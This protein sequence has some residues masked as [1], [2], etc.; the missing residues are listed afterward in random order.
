MCLRVLSSL[1]VLGWADMD[2]IETLPVGC[3]GGL[4]TN[5][6]SLLQASQLQGTAI[7]LEN[8]EPTVEGGYRRINGYTKWNAKRVPF[9]GDLYTVGTYSIGATAIT[10]TNLFPDDYTEFTN[11]LTFTIEISSTTY[12]VTSTSSSNFNTR[13]ITVNFTPALDVNLPTTYR[14]FFD[15]YLDK[16][17]TIYVSY[18]DGVIVVGPYGKVFVSQNIY[19]GGGL[20]ISRDGWRW[21]PINNGI[22]QVN[23]AGQTGNSLNVKGL[24]FA[25]FMGDNFVLNNVFYTVQFSTALSNGTSTLTISPNLSSS[26]SDSASITWLSSYGSASFI[27]NEVGTKDS[28]R[29]SFTKYKNNILAPTISFLRT[30]VTG[31]RPFVIDR[32][33]RLYIIADV[34]G[35]RY[36]AYF[37][38]TLF[39]AQRSNLIFSA[40]YNDLN[41]NVADG[42]G[43]ISFGDQ[44]TGLKSLRD[45]LIV[46]C[47][48]SIYRLIGSSSED[49]RTE[50]ISSSV[51]CISDN[52]IKEING[53]VI[54]MTDSGLCLL[55]DTEKTS[56]L[57]IT[58]VSDKIKAEIN[59]LLTPVVDPFSQS[60]YYNSIYI[61]NKS[62]YRVFQFKDSVTDANSI[63]IIASKVDRETSDLSFSKLKGFKVFSCDNLDDATDNSSLPVPHQAVFANGTDGWV[64]QM[65]S[66][67]TFDGTNITATYSTPYY[68][69]NDSKFRKTIHKVTVYTE[70]E[71][72]VT[73]TIDTVLD[74]N[75]SDIIQPPP[76]IVGT[77]GTTYND[78]TTPVFS[79]PLIGNGYSVSLK[80][81]S[82]TNTPPYVIQSFTVE[83]STND[84]R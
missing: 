64:Y 61:K 38:N 17:L 56:G 27:D 12:T 19:L 63:G 60:V 81:T 37:K 84:R 82:N 67:N 21:I 1:L 75:K 14:L 31:D 80:F 2:R 54:F 46:F 29:L 35:V 9:F 6:P 59:N 13:S 65:D 47:K 11:G 7:D 62:Q 20:P 50:L 32:D 26:P 57:G 53:D 70:A 55:S 8:F 4:V 42:A 39:F 58:L 25:P 73:T 41:F 44:I 34:V 45:S 40:P 23:G 72:A 33:V 68:F 30:A 15:K 66:G 43:V 79:T 22:T 71:G 52:T 48:T 77:T 49:F 3:S 83:Y 16:F 18:N 74:Y 5:V 10:I 69:F 78:T 28:N 36:T 24:R 51:G 76:V